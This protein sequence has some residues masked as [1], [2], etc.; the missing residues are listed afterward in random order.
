MLGREDKSQA[1]HKVNRG[2]T[3]KISYLGVSIICFN[4]LVQIINSGIYARVTGGFNT[5]LFRWT[6]LYMAGLFYLIDCVLLLVALI[7][8]CRSLKNDPQVMGNEIWMGTHSV[9]LFLIL[10]SSI[11]AYL[12]STKDSNTSIEIVVCSNTIVYILMAFIMD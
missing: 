7:W 11:Y 6:E 1:K 10:G 2:I 12:P 3:K 4:Y 5:T 9:F 8:I